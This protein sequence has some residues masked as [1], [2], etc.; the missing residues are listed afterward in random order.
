MSISINRIGYLSGVAASAATV[1]YVVV[2]LLQISGTLRF[3]FD[4]ILIYGSSFC[5]VVPFVFEILSL[6]YLTEPNKRFW[7]HGAL[8]FATAYLV[9]V[10]S[11][12]VVQLA[13]I[14]PAKLRGSIDDVRMFDQTPHSFFWDYDALGYICMG[15]AALFAVPAVGKEGLERRVRLALVI[16]AFVTPLIGAV[17]FYPAFTAD[18]ILFLGLPWAFTAPTFMLLLGLMLQHKKATS[19]YEVD[20][21]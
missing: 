12:Y 8:I 16:H 3:P 14:I 18:L 5:I 20:A 4:E 6:H 13:T 17:Y 19:I 11:N 2:Q 10:S 21:S 1:V 9:F 15:L 7:T